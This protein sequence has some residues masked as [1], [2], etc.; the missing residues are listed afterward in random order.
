MNEIVRT[1]SNDLISQQVN[2]VTTMLEDFGLPSDN[3]LANAQERQIIDKNLPVYL[4][5]LAPEIK[6]DARYL[7][8]FVVG[9]G[10]G[11]FDYALNSVWN[12]VAIALQKKAI[13]YGIEIFFDAAVGGKLREA[14]KTEEDLP[15]LKDVVLLDTCKKLELIAKTTYK[16]LAYILDMRN[17]IGISH[18]TNYV[19]N[20]FE[21]LSWL[22]TCVQDVLN[23]QPSGAAIQ[24]KAF[25]ENLRKGT[26][27]LDD[28]Q[29]KTIAPRIES[30]ASYHC[31]NILKTLFG[32][33][34]APDTSSVVRKNISLL[35]PMVWNATPEEP[36]YKLGIALEGYNNNLNKEK[37]NLGVTF[38]M[39]CGGN[40]YRSPTERLVAI[41]SLNQELL[42]KHRG[43]DNFYH[44]VPIIQSIMSYIETSADIPQEIASS[45][46]E[47]IILCRIGRGV[48]YNNGVSPVGKRYYSCFFN[49]LGDKYAPAFI[50][51]LTDSEIQRQLENAIRLKQCHEM[52]QEVKSFVLDERL[53]ECLQYMLDNFKSD[54]K[55]ICNSK[56]KKLSSTL[57]KWN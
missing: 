28:K 25:I 16:K 47:T 33:F 14:Y 6:K 10:F 8:K 13:A 31:T 52:I 51:K 37:H 1:E 39:V 21:L 2:A 29:V 53:L 17:D 32:I 57:L 35:A 34:V 38:F 11:L 49:L 46:I 44:E 36:K 9:A 15:G 24:V 5:T 54:G 22:Q 41:E 23:D 12:E 27:I 55:A 26:D 45:L 7:S 40:R 56:F 4:R 50:E 30:L 42:D 3:I 18:P 48:A 43:L 20:A 19:I